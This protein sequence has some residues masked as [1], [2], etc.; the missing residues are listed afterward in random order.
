LFWQWCSTPCPRKGIEKTGTT[1]DSE[2]DANNR[3]DDQTE[4][5]IETRMET[6]DQKPEET[7]HAEVVVRNLI[8]NI[9]DKMSLSA[10]G[11]VAPSSLK[12]KG[13]HSAG[14]MA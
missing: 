12:V 6:E 1:T 10:G 9:K 11:L 7:E 14:Q 5:Q 8:T 2:M 4:D 13:R 3:I